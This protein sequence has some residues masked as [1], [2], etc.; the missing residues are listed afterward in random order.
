MFYHTCFVHNCPLGLAPQIDVTDEWVRMKAKL[1]GLFEQTEQ[2][3]WDHSGCLVPRRDLRTGFTRV[4]LER[5]PGGFRQWYGMLSLLLLFK[6]G[7]FGALRLEGVFPST[8]QFLTI[9]ACLYFCVSDGTV[10]VVCFDSLLHL[11]SQIQ[12]LSTDQAECEWLSWTLFGKLP[13]PRSWG[14]DI[15]CWVCNLVECFCVAFWCSHFVIWGFTVLFSRSQWGEPVA[16]E[17]V[18][19]YRLSQDSQTLTVYAHLV[20][21]QGQ[22]LNTRCVVW[23]NR[24]PL[25]T[26]FINWALPSHMAKIVGFYVVFVPCFFISISLHHLNNVWMAEVGQMNVAQQWEEIP[27]WSDEPANLLQA[28]HFCCILLS[29]FLLFAN[30]LLFFKWW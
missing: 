12:S 14:G 8:T 26:Q 25:Q 16:G 3:A 2:L 28:T 21:Q 29:L 15:K 7:A 19:D 27:F 9:V 4:W 5:T 22:V 23:G 18:E 30:S 24:L 10:T 1:F 11:V 17:K 20:R 13:L 6:S